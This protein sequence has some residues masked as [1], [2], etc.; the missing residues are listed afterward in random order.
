MN[1]LLFF[2]I[3][4]RTPVTQNDPLGALNAEND[5]VEASSE[6]KNDQERIAMNNNTL[7]TDQPIL[8]KGHR[9]ATFDEGMHPHRSM[10]R[11]ETMPA[12]SVTSSLANF[13]S[14]LKFNFG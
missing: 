3:S 6:T 11:S 4:P 9:S 1:L 12:N 2:R 7:Y 10:H 8:F 13:G 14:S 5:A